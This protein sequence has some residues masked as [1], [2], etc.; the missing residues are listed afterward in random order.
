[1]EHWALQLLPVPAYLA[2]LGSVT[3]RATAAMA[4]QNA[5]GAL[6]ALVSCNLRLP[7]TSS[8]Q[9]SSSAFAVSLLR[10][11]AGGAYLDKTIVTERVLHVTKHFEKIDPGKVRSLNTASSVADSVVAHRCRAAAAGSGHRQL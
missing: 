2:S 5:A 11:L 3:T 1:V 10:G 6:R 9:T 4:L 8:L 7:V